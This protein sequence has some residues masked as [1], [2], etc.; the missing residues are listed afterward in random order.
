MISNVEDYISV[1]TNDHVNNTELQKKKLQSFGGKL[2]KYCPLP[3]EFTIRNLEFDI[4][5]YSTPNTFN[6]PFDCFLGYDE[7]AFIEEILLALVFDKRNKIPPSQYDTFYKAIIHSSLSNEE[8][9]II[10]NFVNITNKKYNTQVSIN[11]ILSEDFYIRSKGVLN[12]LTEKDE[13]ISEDFSSFLFS[14]CKNNDLQLKVQEGINSL[15]GINCFCE[16]YDNA[17]MWSH[18]ANKHSGICIE[19]D[20]NKL[21]ANHIFLTTLFPVIYTTKRQCLPTGVSSDSNNKL[22]INK[23]HL[24]TYQIIKSLITKSDIWNS[25]HEWRSINWLSNL[26]S[27]QNIRLPIISKVFLGVNISSDFKKQ[28]I[29]ICKHKN[30][31]IAEMHLSRSEYKLCVNYI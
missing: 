16:S 20:L 23:P 19:Y 27:N 24:T 30:I 14:Q 1:F 6:D 25:E 4:L 31:S 10:N 17:L 26:D 2:Y 11:E 9:N 22:I 5:H 7:I 18:Y 28:I 3:N 8:Y 29:E 12:L 21:S 13:L 15:Y